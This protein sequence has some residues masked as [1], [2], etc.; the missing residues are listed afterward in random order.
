MSTKIKADN[1]LIEAVGVDSAG[2][3]RSEPGGRAR[4][5]AGAA[6][7]LEDRLPGEVCDRL[8]DDVIDELLAGARTDSRGVVDA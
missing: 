7:L 6:C 8:A 4:R 1:E 2:G 3:L 5:P